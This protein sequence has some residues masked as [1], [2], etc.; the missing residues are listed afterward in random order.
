MELDKAA[1]DFLIDKGYNPDFGARPL[2]RAI[3]AY[4]EDPLAEALLSGDYKS[5]Q[6]RIVTRKEDAEN[7]FFDAEDLPKDDNGGDDDS[8]SSSGDTGGGE[9]SSTGGEQLEASTGDELDEP[10]P[11]DASSTGTMAGADTTGGGC[12]MGPRGAPPLELLL[13]LPLLGLVRR[14]R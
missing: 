5:G 1:K 2:R 12:S 4:I 11:S 6:K 3:S 8:G 7:L 13:G 14:R 9:E 10:S